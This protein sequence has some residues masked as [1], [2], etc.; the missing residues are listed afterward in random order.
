[1]AAL[2][3]ISL[4]G[5]ASAQQAAVAQPLPDW[6]A[7]WTGQATI[8]AWI[9]SVNGAQQGPDGEPLVDLNQNDVLSRLDMAFMGAA[10]L[11]KDKWGLLLDIVYADLSNDGA[12][13]QERVTTSTGIKLGVYSLAAAYRVYDADRSFADVY[14]GARYFA[15]TLTFDIASR[16]LGR[17]VKA[18]LDWA[19]PIVGVR[20][21]TPL[22]GRWTVSGFADVG[23]FDG[24]SDLSWEVYGGANYAFS[25]HWAGTIGYRYMSIL[26]E[27]SDRA[28]LD[29]D[30]QGPV[31]GVTYKF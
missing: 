26:Y 8:Y 22:G 16:N 28:K 11:R 25:Q 4:G 6:S 20:G 31:F 13:L 24:S 2:A 15:S 23:G 30:V 1:L 10:E 17:N 3:L 14:A 12:W 5:T 9:P 29:I 19:D 27:A 21:A 18:T 7:G